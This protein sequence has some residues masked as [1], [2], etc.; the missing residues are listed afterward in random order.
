MVNTWITTQHD[1]LV[2]LFTIGIIHQATRNLQNLN[3]KKTTRYFTDNADHESMKLNMDSKTEIEELYEDEVPVLLKKDCFKPLTKFKVS[4]C[5]S[6]SPSTLLKHINT[7][8]I[9]TST[10]NQNYQDELLGPSLLA[11]LQQK[12]DIII[13]SDGSKSKRKSGGAWIIV[14]SSGN[15]ATS[16]LNPN[17]DPITS[18]NSHRS[19]ICGVLSALLFFINT[20]A[21]SWYPFLLTLN[22]SVTTLKS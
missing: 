17:F 14:D 19:E 13:A 7:L 6:S 5:I 18:M 15:I 10:L 1:S 21:T 16:G 11:I 4:A 2:A 3:P 22:T 12:F 8:P 20:V 9:W